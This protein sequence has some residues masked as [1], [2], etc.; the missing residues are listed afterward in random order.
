MKITSTH[1]SDTLI[2]LTVEIDAETLALAKEH[3]VDK[4]G[5]EIKVQGFRPGKAP[6]NMLAAA[7]NPALLQE[8]FLN[9]AMNHAYSQ[10][11][12]DEMLRPVDQPKVEVTKF[13]PYD[14][15]EFT[16]EVAVIGNVKLGDYKN[17]KAKKE[18]AE[19]KAEDVDRVIENMRQQLAERS[20][21]ERVAQ[22]GDQVTIDFDGTDDK[23]AEIKGASGKAYP[24][25]LGSNTFIPGFEEHVV[26]LKTGDTKTFDIAFPKDYGVKAL[27]S[28]KATFTVTVMKVEE[29]KKPEL[30]AAFVKKV[31]P[32]IADM[33]ALKED[34]KRQLLVEQEGNVQRAYENALLGELIEKS[35]VSIPQALIDQQA[36]LV[37]RDLRQNILY[38]GQTMEEYLAAI[39]MTEEEQREKEII[40]E[41]VRRVKGGVVLAEVADKENISLTPEELDIRISVLKQRYKGDE[42]MQAELDKPENRQDVGNQVITEKSIARLVSL[43]S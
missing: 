39:G 32:E 4:L 41:A 21:V 7:I 16:A 9:E 8:E 2:K 14:I 25:V 13:V 31:A 22:D 43:N 6:K 18:K 36:E 30:D 3:A 15:V 1:I 5:K 29:I 26:G 27:Q 12:R 19:V 28:K 42:K 17:L 20:E 37:M 35:E 11:V 40:P 24:L 10:A 34:I 23:G 33:A 38:R